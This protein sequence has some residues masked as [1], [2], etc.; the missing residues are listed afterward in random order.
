MRAAPAGRGEP[1]DAVVG[2]T[3]RLLAAAPEQA[4]QPVDRDG[5]GVVEGRG[6][7]EIVADQPEPLP[8]HVLVPCQDDDA[9][10]GDPAQFPQPGRQVA[11]VVDGE[12]RH[13]GIGRGGGKR[14]TFRDRL[15]GRCRTLRPLGDHDP[16]GLDSEDRTRR[17]VG[18]RPRSDVD[19]IGGVSQRA[20]DLCGDPWIRQTCPGIGRAER[21]VGGHGSQYA[22]PAGVTGPAVGEVVSV[23]RI[24]G[25][26]RPRGLRAC[27]SRTPGDRWCGRSGSSALSAWTADR[28]GRVPGP[29]RWRGRAACPARRPR[30][31]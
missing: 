5:A 16:A 12:Q 14:E 22:G 6:L 29:G 20:A 25:G 23:S 17:L 9:A 10:A 28:P 26:A 19:H 15:H 21:V 18:T 11:P 13:D 4:E 24:G 7:R 2:D 8:E 3:D 27:P 31:R 1:V 30:D